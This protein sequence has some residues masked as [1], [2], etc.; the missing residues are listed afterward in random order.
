MRLLREVVAPVL[1]AYVVVL[2][3]L[4]SYR[5]ALAGRGTRALRQ[6]PIPS[7]WRELVRDIFVMAVAG[8]GFFLL[9]VV[10]F[11]FILGAHSGRL[12]IDALGYGSL[13]T[14]AVVVPV[15][16]VF[17]WLQSRIRDRRRTASGAKPDRTR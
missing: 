6:R 4:F 3:M 17:S 9:L 16:L 12:V 10:V 15:F 2:A 14:F 7:G 11:Y 13:L 1:T 8:Y 5:R